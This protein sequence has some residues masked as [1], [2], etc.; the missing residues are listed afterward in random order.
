MIAVD[1]SVVV[2]LLT[3]DEPAQTRHARSFFSAEPIWLAKTVLLETAWV[4]HSFYGLE[5]AAIHDALRGLLGLDNV[6]AED[7]PSVAAALNLTTHGIDFA[8]ALHLCSRP[9]GVRFA[10]FDNSLVRR[11]QRAGAPA[12]TG[13]PQK[14]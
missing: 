14:R 12:V 10:S 9:Q 4:L 6:H 11:A 8:D 1:T 3:A 13:V 7:E 5:R 2:R